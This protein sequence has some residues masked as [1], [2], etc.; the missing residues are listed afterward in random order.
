MTGGIVQDGWW[1]VVHGTRLGCLRVHYHA[2]G[3]VTVGRQEGGRAG[4]FPVVCLCVVV[5]VVGSCVGEFKLGDGSVML[6]CYA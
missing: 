5:V 3:P 6:V 2:P 4:C 1:I